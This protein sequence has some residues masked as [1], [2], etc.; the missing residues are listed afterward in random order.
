[1][2]RRGLQ[3]GV[4]WY[5]H[6]RRAF[7]PVLHPRIP[8]R[9][10]TRCG[11]QYS[12][13]AGRRSSF[14]IHK[15]PLLCIQTWHLPSSH[16]P[17]SVTPQTSSSRYS[18]RTYPLHAE[19][20]CG[21]WS[22]NATGDVLPATDIRISGPFAML[23]NVCG[24]SPLTHRCRGL[25]RINHIPVCQ[26]SHIHTHCTFTHALAH[27]RSPRNGRSPANTTDS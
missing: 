27:A 18:Y 25:R 24:A 17:R 7:F 21:G 14:A 12:Q 10:L 4:M 20:P 1:M 6:S 15:A 5:R 13:N 26:C 11:Q 9:R 8:L 3:R 16:E 23:D 2:L 22:T 19:K